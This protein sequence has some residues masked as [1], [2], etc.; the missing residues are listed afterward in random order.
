[1][2]R[3]MVSV[4]WPSVPIRV[5]KKGKKKLKVTFPFVRGEICPGWKLRR[6]FN[7]LLTH[8]FCLWKNRLIIK[9]ILSL[10]QR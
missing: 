9:K 8:E 5:T 6:K 2:V 1:M 3:E 7:V 4:I 10:H